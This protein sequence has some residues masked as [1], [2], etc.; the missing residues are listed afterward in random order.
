MAW[1]QILPWQ[2]VTIIHGPLKLR[3]SFKMWSC[4]SWSMAS[5][6]ISTIAVDSCGLS[7]R[8]RVCTWNVGT[9][10]L[11]IYRDLETDFHSSQHAGIKHIIQNMY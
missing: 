11:H 7:I 8:L 5:S 2:M 4:L 9:M 10:H 3:D 6:F 1:T